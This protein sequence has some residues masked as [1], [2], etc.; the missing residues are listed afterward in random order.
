LLRVT[1]TDGMRTFRAVANVP[2]RRHFE[3][4]EIIACDQNQTVE[5]T[6]AIM[7]GLLGVA[8]L[9]PFGFSISGRVGRD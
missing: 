9:K 2:A 6:P 3:T 4:G 1:L 7:D 8:E 5:V